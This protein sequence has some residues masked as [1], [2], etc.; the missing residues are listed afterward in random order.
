[1]TAVR[2]VIDANALAGIFDLP[3]AF[4]GRKIEVIL[5]PVE[6]APTPDGSS[7][8]SQNGL[9]RFTAAQI[10]EWAKAPEIK[11]LAGALRGTGLS[12]N[13]S[14]A[15]IRDQRPCL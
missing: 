7:A 13:T 11:S 12:T 15:E 5:L 2:K 14:M 4:M 6:E 9:P 3:P 10:E 1:M 8:L